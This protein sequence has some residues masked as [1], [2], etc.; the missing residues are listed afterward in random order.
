MY[1]YGRFINVNSASE[2]GLCRQY[3][4]AHRFPFFFQQEQ[5]AGFYADG[6]I[7][8]IKRSLRIHLELRDC[9][10]FYK[11][12]AYRVFT[13][14]VKCSGIQCKKSDLYAVFKRERRHPISFYAF[15]NADGGR[16]TVKR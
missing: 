8:K 13:R 1:A 9:P 2:A 4:C 3:V 11:R 5:C 15:K 10:L 14:C 7:G 6:I 12:R 16:C